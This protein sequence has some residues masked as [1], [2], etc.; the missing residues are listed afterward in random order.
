M[1]E[2]KGPIVELLEKRN[3]EVYKNNSGAVIAC[4]E[5]VGLREVVAGFAFCNPKDFPGTVKSRREWWERGVQIAF[6]R[7]KNRRMISLDV[8]WMDE[9]GVDE[10]RN[11]KAVRT[12][13]KEF[14]FEAAGMDYR[15]N[16]VLLP[17]DQFCRPEGF[18][19]RK[20]NNSKRCSCEFQQWMQEFMMGLMREERW[21]LNREIDRQKAEQRDEMKDEKV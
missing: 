6:G 15:K 1:K 3:V 17:R 10:K 19:L 9:D 2:D 7:M 13:L 12:A 5:R 18:G 20:Y 8:D 4:W 21:L 11:N 14:L 16:A